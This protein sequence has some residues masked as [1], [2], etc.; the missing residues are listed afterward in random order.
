MGQQHRKVA[1]RRR[2]AA[3]LERKKAK[4]KQHAPSPRREPAKPKG[5]KQ[6]ATAAAKEAAAKS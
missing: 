2:R 4:T 5:K 1:K 6:T 3:Y